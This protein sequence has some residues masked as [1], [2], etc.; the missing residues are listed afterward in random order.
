MTGWQTAPVWHGMEID[1]QKVERGHSLEVK[2]WTLCVTGQVSCV[3]FGAGQ[4]WVQTV[5]CEG[6][7]S[8]W[9]TAGPGPSTAATPMARPG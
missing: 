4:S 8:V 6:Q 9:G 2:H 3:V 5:S 1:G 7:D